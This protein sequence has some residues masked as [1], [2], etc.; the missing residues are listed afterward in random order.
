VVETATVLLAYDVEVRT[1]TP[2]IPNPEAL[3]VEMPSS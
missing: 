1:L 2:P 3:A